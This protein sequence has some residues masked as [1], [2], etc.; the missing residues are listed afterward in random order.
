[1][2][3]V[4]VVK[5]DDKS[6]DPETVFRA[7]NKAMRLAGWEKRVSGKN[8]VLKVN[9]VWDKIYPSC[10]TTPMVI[11]GILKTV[12]SS[13][14]IRPNRITIVDTDTAAIVRA[15]V[16]FKI[17]GIEKMANKYGVEVVNLRNT[18]FVDIK[19][20]K[21]GVLKKLRVSK[22]LLDADPII[23]VPVLKTHSYSQLTGALKNQ[24][25]CIHDLR[26]NF[27]MVLND[28]IPDV[29]NFFKG[30]IRF[31]L[32]DGLFG[33]EGKGPKTGRPR[34]IGYIFAS[35]DLVGLD[36]VVATVMGIDP[37]SV[38]H[39]VKSQRIGLGSM[40][41]KGAGEAMPKYSFERAD[42]SNIVMGTE[43]RLRHLGP[44]IEW[45]MFNSKSPVLFLFRWTAKAYYDIWYQLVGI[46][47]VRKMMETNFGRMWSRYYL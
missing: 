38:K 18:E 33:M 21:G 28:A 9:V 24:W 5:V 13:K 4:S 42:R 15:D 44:K 6:V 45:L 19:F 35:S 34:K 17:Q 8:L 26:H 7:V 11:E 1:M 14:K 47:Y 46:K 40:K 23:T 37:Y 43:M 12:L 41:G 16:S 27:H 22:V 29:N 10:T 32:M 30:K 36:T 39:I 2:S 25:G 31:A 3:V 20:E